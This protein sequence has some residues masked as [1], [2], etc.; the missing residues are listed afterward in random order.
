MT[1]TNDNLVTRR[2]RTI[3]FNVGQCFHRGRSEARWPSV[4]RAG[5]G[6]GGWDRVAS[7]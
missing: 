7:N 2:K 3:S 1:G 4:R 5:V 6:G